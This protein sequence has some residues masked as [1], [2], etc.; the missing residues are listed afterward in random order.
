MPEVAT[1]TLRE[2][3][4]AGG[5]GKTARTYSD[6]Y[7][8]GTRLLDLLGWPEADYITPLGWGRV[9]CQAD[10]VAELLRRRNPSLPT[11]RCQLYICPECGDIGCGAVTV[12]VE[13]EGE[14]IVWRDF[15]YENDY[16]KDMP[17]LS[18]FATIAPIYFD[19][20]AYWQV[21]SS[22]RPHETQAA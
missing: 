16:E 21:L 19:A 18:E 12:R 10:A 20:T 7:V 6:F 15:G 2:A 11:G 1:L 13:R 17:R 4:R 14:F 9:E 8:S 3:H 5:G 22:F